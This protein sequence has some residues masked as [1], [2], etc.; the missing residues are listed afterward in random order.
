MRS[1]ASA[2]A[3]ALEAAFRATTYRIETQTGLFDLRIGE[4]NPAFDA[5][6]QATGSACW[7][8]ITASNPGGVRCDADNPRQAQRLRGCLQALGHV[9]LSASHIADDG[10]WPEEKGFLVLQASEAELR[11]LA[12]DF[13]QLA[14]VTGTVGGKARLIWT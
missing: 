11:S 6:L 13:S 2:S 10:G 1:S 5:Y 12:A 8:V 9:F 7:G 14:F 4:N 3:R